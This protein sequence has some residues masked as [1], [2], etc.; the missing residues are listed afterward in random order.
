[1]ISPCVD[2]P[3][4]TDP[5]AFIPRPTARLRAAVD[6]Q[7][8]MLSAE[9]FAGMISCVASLYG[10]YREKL[11][12][13]AA[14][15]ERA[16]WLHEMVD[17]EMKATD[18][19]ALSCGKGC[20]GCCSYEVEVTAD[21]AVL[22]ADAVRR[23]TTIDFGRMARQ[24]GRERKGPE[25]SRYGDPDNRCVFLGDDGACRIYEDRPASCRKHVVTTPAS[26]CTTEGA[27]VAPVQVLLA[28]ILVSA[29][30]SIEDTEVASVSKLVT[31]NLLATAGHDSA[32]T[33][34]RHRAPSGG[35][36]GLPRPGT[37]PE[38]RRNAAP[39]VGLPFSV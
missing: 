33:D 9:D 25:W 4:A 5:I 21:E 20:A 29:A 13:F 18:G 35:G 15:A 38:V 17:R 28:E 36:C 34:A 3:A 1:M 30:L 39:R 24:A 8:T 32:E 16:R 14:G 27:S 31:K 11:R 37:S 2:T 6:Q 22:L 23:G 10:K 12:S 7:R 26:A 19:I